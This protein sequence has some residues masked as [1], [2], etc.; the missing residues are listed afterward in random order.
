MS[1]GGY[2]QK[3]LRAYLVIFGKGSLNKPGKRH[4]LRKF[5]IKDALYTPHGA[6]SR[7]K[8]FNEIDMDSR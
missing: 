6:Q 5:Y 1:Y 2:L 7:D 4:R 8:A 3:Y